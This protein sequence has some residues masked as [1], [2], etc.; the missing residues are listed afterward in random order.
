MTCVVTDATTGKTELRCNIRPGQPAEETCD[1][2]DSDCDGT[3]D[4]VRGDC[5][6]GPAGTKD[7]GACRGGQWACVGAT[8]TCVGGVLPTAEDC[9]GVDNNCNGEVDEGCIEPSWPATCHDKRSGPV[10][11][12]TGNMSFGPLELVSVATPAGSPLRLEVTY[13]SRNLRAGALGIGWT[14]NLEQ[15]VEASAGRYTHWGAAGTPTPFAAPAGTAASELFGAPLP[16]T[17]RMTRA[18]DGSN[19]GFYL[20]FMGTRL[21]QC[22]PGQPCGFVQIRE[23]R[24][25]FDDG[26]TALFSE[27]GALGGFRDAAGNRQLA[28]GTTIVN[29]EAVTLPAGLRQ[30]QRAVSLAY[31]VS[32][33]THRVTSA[34]VLAAVGGQTTRVARA[35]LDAD[36]YLTEVCAPADGRP[37][38]DCRRTGEAATPCGAAGERTLWRFH[39]RQVCAGGACDA[40]KRLEEVMDERCL[41]VER[42]DYARVG[43]LG[44]VATTADTGRERLQFDFAARDA[45]VTEVLVTQLLKPAAAPPGNA[46]PQSVVSRTAMDT[47]VRRVATVDATCGCGPQLQ[48]TWGLRDGIPVLAAVRNGLALTTFGY[49]NTAGASLDPHGFGQVTSEVRSDPTAFASPAKSLQFAW[50]HPLVRRPTSVTEPGAGGPP[51]TSTWDYDDDDPAFPCRDYQ[52]PGTGIPSAANESP[53]RLLCRFTEAGTGGS[54]STHF[55]YDATGRL[56]RSEGPDGVVVSY[57]Y[58]R[59]DDADVARAGMLSAVTRTAAGLSLTTAYERYHFTGRPERIV[60]PNGETTDIVYDVQGRPTQV[61]GPVGSGASATDRAV[62]TTVWAA[63]NAPATV[64]LPSGTVVRS[65]WDAWGRLEYVTWAS[66]TGALLQRRHLAYDNGGNAIVEETFDSAGSRTGRRQ[67]DF[68]EAHRVTQEFGLSTSQ[69]R[70]SEY[71]HGLLVRSVDEDGTV[72][73]F[74]HDGFE[75]LRETRQYRPLTTGPL[76]VTALGY[77]ARDNL[78]TL[79]DGNGNRTT[80]RHDDFGQVREVTSPNSGATRYFYSADGQVDFVETAAMRPGNEVLR[81]LYDGLRRRTEERHTVYSAPLGATF[82]TGVPPT[83]VPVPRLVVSDTTLVRYGYDNGP[84]GRGRLTSVDFPGGGRALTYD[85]AGRPRD[86]TWTLQG[87]STPLVLTRG[88]HAGGALKS[89]TYPPQVPGTPPPVLEFDVDFA[90]EV[91]DVRFGGATL[92][93]RVTHYPFGGGLRRLQRG[94]GLVT[95][96]ERDALGRP[97]EVRGGPVNFSYDYSP[98]GDVRGITE[99]GDRP[100][101]RAFGYDGVHR[102]TSTS[103]TGPGGAAVFSEAF[104]YDEAGNR[105]RKTTNGTKHFVSTFDMKTIAGGGQ[106]PAND[107]LRAVVDPATAGECERPG[108]GGGAGGTG[109]RQCPPGPANRDIAGLEAGWKDVVR[110]GMQLLHDAPGLSP[111]E[112][113][114]RGWTVVELLRAWMERWDISA[115]ALM[116]VLSGTRDGPVDFASTLQAYLARRASGAAFGEEDMALLKR[117]VTL[118]EKARVR[119]AVELDPTWRY[120]HDA[121][122]AVTSVTVELPALTLGQGPGGPIR[123]GPVHNTACY[124]HDAR[125]RLVRV[126]TVSRVG[127][128]VTSPTPPCDDASRVPVAEFRYDEGNRRVY[129]RVGGVESWEVRGAGGEVLAEVS[130]SG[131]VERAFVYLDGQPLAMV[132]RQAGYSSRPPSTPAGCS[133]TGGGAAAAALGLLALALAVGHRRRSRV[134]WAVALWL[135]LVAAGCLSDEAPPD[136]GAA[137][138]ADEEGGGGRHGAE[139]PRHGREGG[140]GPS[141]PGGKL[142]DPVYYFHNDALGT[143]VRLT[144]ERGATVWRAEYKSFGDLNR[145]E[146]DVDGDGTHVEQPLRFPGQSDDA[147]SSMLLA[148]GPYYNWNRWYEPATGRELSPESLQQ[149]PAYLRALASTGYS[150]PAYA[151]ALNNPIA[152]VDADGND[153][154]RPQGPPPTRRSPPG[155]TKPPAPA[156]PP[157]PVPEPAKKTFCVS[158]C[159]TLGQKY[160]WEFVA[161]SDYCAW[162]RLRRVVE[163]VD[164]PALCVCAEKLEFKLCAMSFRICPEVD[165]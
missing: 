3:P 147:L 163:C 6:S 108:N 136:A 114:N 92:A 70:L 37:L 100:R 94:N 35:V 26:T 111:V 148:Q 143:P 106:V 15:R 89:L 137:A 63:G 160:C 101:W 97:R 55:R 86:E 129:A 20:A 132:V 77:D 29:G 87:L 82:C 109:P 31:V 103:S 13:N 14:L 112:V 45:A 59:D 157:V 47:A 78:V 33:T 30:G 79:D 11:M 9:D 146:T 153:S 49:G 154:R 88:Y 65:S 38:T 105:L 72:T 138:T 10:S 34:D 5:Y 21:P 122:G 43:G 81:Y 140:A 68:D 159:P 161:G 164:E 42:H 1:G 95:T 126:E 83:C 124:R 16:D 40:T 91:S 145:L 64:T 36:G 142:Q 51:R 99:S 151:Y 22:P 27:A 107:L 165:R 80:Y 66:P 62:T 41:V 24:V 61:T 58:H 93:S 50:L 141:T 76:V 17:S 75:R 128:A 46:Q 8:R 117:L 85:A 12:A 139:P 135:A 150:A 115:P 60:E 52:A 162:A 32:Q 116:A 158:D 39:Y 44:V 74:A 130:A 4:N 104:G 2:R 48:R 102:L 113:S 57:T 125:Q 118:A 123:F 131:A 25:V 110:A 119:L 67:R 120:T 156:A 54:R 98:A 71:R 155:A 19:L 152:F 96:I 127:A 84:N 133:S 144:D 149:S 18:L 53:G 73:E 56:V 28:L 90:D 69:V 121:N 7:V 134:L 23:P